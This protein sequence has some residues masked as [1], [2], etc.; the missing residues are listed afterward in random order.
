VAQKSVLVTGGAGFIGSHTTNLLVEC[1]YYVRVMDNLSPPVH[2]EGASWPE[3][4][5]P[6]AERMRGD[7]RVAADWRDALDGV[8]CVI[9]LA[10][11]QDLLPTF[12]KFFHTNALHCFTRP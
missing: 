9:H 7:V 2:A 11:H 8:D 4:L 3:W 5:H 1:G 12:G 10:A 6:D